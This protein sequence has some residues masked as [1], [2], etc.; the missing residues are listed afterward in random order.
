[1]TDQ[2]TPGGARLVG[3]RYELTEQI[4][5]GGMAE[6]WAARDSRL[7][8]SVAVKLL[9]TDL[10][11]DP[12]FQ[13]RF[14]REA[15]SSAS[16]NH[17]SIV[18]VYDTGEDTA[19]DP[20]GHPAPQPF[21]VMEH[22]RGRTVKQI[23]QESSPLD[24]DDSMRITA[25]VLD[26]LQYSH[27][28]GIIHRDIKPG[29]VM[30]T[31]SG[32][33]KV[34]DFGIARAMADTSAT[35]TGTNAVLGTAQY[36][37]PEQ[38]RG[39]TVDERSD[40]YSAGCLL[41][42]LLTGRPPFVGENALA[43]AYQHVGETPQP[44]SSLNPEVPGDL[45]NVVLHALAKGRDERYQDAGDFIADLDRVATG[46]PVAAPPAAG[47]AG[48][49][50]ALMPAA[51]AGAATQRLPRTVSEP[52]PGW[53][54]GPQ[55][56]YRDELDE[57]EEPK[58]R[59]WLYVLLVVLALGLIGV[60]F[61]L[62]AGGEDEPLVDEVRMP[63][64]VGL[65]EDVAV[66]ELQTLGFTDVTTQPDE[67]SEAPAGEVVAQEPEPSDT[68]T[69]VPVDTPV[70]LTVATGP[71]EVTVPDVSG[72]T[73]AEAR[74]QLVA[75]GLVFAGTSEEDDPDAERGTVLSSDPEAG[76]TV[77]EGS[78]VTLVLASGQNAVPDVVGLSQ[79]EAIAALQDAGFAVETQNVD[80]PEEP[81]TVIGQS[82]PSGQRLDIGSTVTLEVAVAPAPSPSTV[83]ETVTPTAE[84]TGEPDGPDG[85]PEPTA[86]PTGE[87][88]AGG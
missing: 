57:E 43:L 27:R 85:P 42:E 33:V 82:S 55:P 73:Q 35:M 40:I 72:L 79:T 67:E 63:D 38:A 52:D 17:P 80:S 30:V 13:A 1:M 88:T 29:N 87:P 2:T 36:L 21:I 78:D 20:Y 51:A 46:V 3:G 4:G 70:V 31:D 58:R 69:L 54:T 76:Q 19:A 23:L 75:A 74:E 44:P 16:L 18:S 26:A 53:P 11:R 28:A 12:S 81:G 14:K 49:A 86:E 8:R 5:R 71:D 68:L 22:V 77:E 83:T 39:E 15:Q 47:V 48:A 66:Q 50:T 9:R 41:Y 37:S 59:A 45:D 60:L 65:Q 61:W 10:A 32:E 6:V 84:P 25:G 24:V 7:G 62:F 34:M 56:P 64:V